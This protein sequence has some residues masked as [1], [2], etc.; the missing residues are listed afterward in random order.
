MSTTSRPWAMSAAAMRLSRMQLPPYIPPAPAVWCTFKG[1]GSPLP[2]P[3][4][5]SSSNRPRPWLSRVSALSG[6]DNRGAYG[7]AGTQQ[8]D[9]TVGVGY[10]PFGV[11]IGELAA[12]LGL[13]LVDERPQS[14]G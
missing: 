9:R 7:E 3:P 13:H 1:R 2:A 14:V 4:Q 8:Q 6:R 12:S 5:E 10:Q 11:A